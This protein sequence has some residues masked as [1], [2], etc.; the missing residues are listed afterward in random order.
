M[1][2]GRHSIVGRIRRLPDSPPAHMDLKLAVNTRSGDTPHH[3]MT[4]T[5]LL[6]GHG[7]LG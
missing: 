4:A 3:T 1:A 5:V 2:A 7:L 6:E